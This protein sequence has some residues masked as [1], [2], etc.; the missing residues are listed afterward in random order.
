MLSQRFPAVDPATRALAAERTRFSRRAYDRAIAA[1]QD[2]PAFVEALIA[3]GYGRPGGYSQREPAPAVVKSARRLSVILPKSGDEK[4][5]V[6]FLSTLTSS[7]E[8]LRPATA[9]AKALTSALA[10]ARGDYVYFADPEA[11]PE[12]GALSRLIDAGD[13]DYA[14]IVRGATAAGD[15]GPPGGAP[16][17]Q[18]GPVKA[19]PVDPKRLVVARGDPP[20]VRTKWGF[21]PGPRALRASSL[22]PHPGAVGDPG[23]LAARGGGGRARRRRGPRSSPR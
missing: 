5:A 16:A 13:R 23:V 14:E 9:N 10:K 4:A 11:P 22:R 6:D 20:A 18:P 12:K 21:R 19:P 7:V 17:Q 3:D 8:V 2:H 1:A 15:D